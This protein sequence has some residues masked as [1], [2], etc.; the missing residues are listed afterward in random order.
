M[1]THMQWA[2]SVTTSGTRQTEQRPRQTSCTDLLYMPAHTVC[3]L[4]AV[5]PITYVRPYCRTAYISHACTSYPQ[6]HV[7]VVRIL[8]NCMSM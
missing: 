2:Q 3:S 5:V 6:V 8:A 7:H 4:P 1:G